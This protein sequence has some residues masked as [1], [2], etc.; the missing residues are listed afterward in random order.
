MKDSQL[1][2]SSDHPTA[3][4]DPSPAAALVQPW[5]NPPPPPP[6]SADAEQPRKLG[7]SS[8]TALF[9]AAPERTTAAPLKRSRLDAFT[10]R[11]LPRRTRSESGSGHRRRHRRLDRG[12]DDRLVIPGT[13]LPFDLNNPCI[14]PLHP[15]VN[16][17]TLRE[18]ELDSI[19]RNPQLRESLI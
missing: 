4:Q 12:L 18:L 3:T 13:P 9:P 1:T 15:P 6:T 8:K 17:S 19:L 10:T 11:T 14:P 5:S 7:E 16:Q 2:T